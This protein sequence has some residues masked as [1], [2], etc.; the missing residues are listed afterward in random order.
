VPDPETILPRA[1]YQAEAFAYR[2]AHSDPEPATP[3]SPWPAP[4]EHLPGESSSVRRS[5]AVCEVLQALAPLTG[6]AFAD[7]PRGVR[8]C[9]AR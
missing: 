4:Q 3:M 9:V 8:V 2:R 6:G 1:G 5:S 7:A